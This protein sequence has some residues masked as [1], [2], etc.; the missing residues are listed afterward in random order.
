MLN[1]LSLNS[2]IDAIIP[3]T[4]FNRGEAGK[5]FDEVR[6]AGCK[7]VVKNN[8]PACVLITPER[9]RKMVELIEDRYL[10]VLA[11]EREKRDSGITCS[12]E[13][14]YN[15]IGLPDEELDLI[16]MEYGVDFE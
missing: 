11:E 10:L 6:E 9:Y 8:T 4:R 3:I 12:A 14:V 16:P 5:I 15:E 2:A 7:I 13:E 1:I